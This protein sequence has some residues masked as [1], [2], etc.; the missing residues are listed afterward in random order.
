MEDNLKKIAADEEPEEGAAEKTVAELKSLLSRKNAE[1]AA[2]KKRLHEKMSEQERNESERQEEMERL[3]RENESFR[4]KDR[5]A[6]YKA[7]LL[8]A[9]FGPDAAETLSKSLPEGIP[10]EFFEAQ[11]RCL[12]KRESEIRGELLKLQPGLSRGERPIRDPVSRET[13]LLR[14]AAGLRD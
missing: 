10:A 13:E 3:R 1:A 9:G 5:A 4:E 12:L 7:A 2:Y 14:R 11:K 8:E 6:G